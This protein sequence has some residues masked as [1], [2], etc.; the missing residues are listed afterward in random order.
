MFDAEEP[1]DQFGALD[2]V[3]VNQEIMRNCGVHTLVLSTLGLPFHNAKAQDNRK[4]T[5]REC[6]QWLVQ[7][8]RNNPRN[9]KAI[10]GP[11]NCKM[12]VKHIQYDIGADKAIVEMFNNNYEL[13]SQVLHQTFA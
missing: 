3:Q 5:M 11:D 13:C 7:F 9:Q 10:Y 8:C 2:H 4:Q 12:F 6:Y 1:E